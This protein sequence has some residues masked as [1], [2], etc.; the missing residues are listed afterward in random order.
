M[1]NKVTLY[2]G[3]TSQGVPVSREEIHQCLAYLTETAGS[4][5]AYQ[6]IG[7]WIDPRG[8]VVMEPSLRVECFISDTVDPQAIAENCRNLLRQESVLVEVDHSRATFVSG[9][10]PQLN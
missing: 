9:A 5:T 8:E 4:C 2:L 7:S 10:L 3:T 1:M 6:A